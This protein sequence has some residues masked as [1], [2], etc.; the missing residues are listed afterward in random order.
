[1]PQGG[2]GRP[3]PKPP[4]AP[5]RSINAAQSVAAKPAAKPRKRTVKK[6]AATPSAAPVAAGLPVPATTPV[7]SIDDQTRK[8]VKEN[9]G[10]YMSHFLE[11]KDIGP[12]ILGAARAGW[13]V[14]KL[15]GEI[16]KTPWWQKTSDSARAWEQHKAEDPASATQ[17]VQKIYANLADKARVMGLQIDDKRLMT[18][19]EDIK[20]FGWDETQIIDGL[21][22]EVSPGGVGPGS[23]TVTKQQIMGIAKKYLLPLSEGVAMDWAMRIAKEEMTLETVSMLLGEQAKARF[24]G[25]ADIIDKGGTPADFFAPYQETAARLLEV[26]S[27]SIDFTKTP[28]SQVLQAPDDPT[29]VM[30]LTDFER[31][32]K[33][34]QRFGWKYTDNANDAIDSLTMYIGDKFGATTA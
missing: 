19:S 20:R 8:W 7:L 24:P 4:V 21:V 5:Q 32:I 29:Q 2:G 23:I 31:V 14:N 12:I 25:L 9:Y 26:P 13:D 6:A 18:M 1:M 28:Y 16:Q 33:Q 30:R 22:K 27:D 11:D 17:E 10:D 34:D 3:Q 15:Y